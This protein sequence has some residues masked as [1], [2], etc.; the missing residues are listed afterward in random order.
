M[1][2]T[3]ELFLAHEDAGYAGQAAR[4][5]FR[6]LDR[7]DRELSRFIPSS[8]VARIN[9][10]AAGES[11]TI[12]LAAWEC[13]ALAAR[14]HARTDGAFDV[15]IGLLLDW[16]RARGDAGDCAND[17]QWLAA[18]ART[19]MGLLAV[20]AGE[21]AVT[22]RE[23][24]VRVD[25]G[26]IGKGYAVD[27]MAALLREWSIQAALIHGGQSSVLAIGS[28]PDRDDWRVSLRNP[29]DH[30]GEPFGSLRLRDRS[31]GGSGIQLHG[32]HIIDP[33]TGRPAEGKLG[34]WVLAPAA[35]QA[36]ALSTAF[37]VLAESEIEEYCRT[38]EEISA[39]LW[40]AEAEQKTLRRW[41]KW[42][43]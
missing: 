1:A 41:G 13:L 23:A 17:P 22:A 6:E 35:A 33:R 24:G 9:S 16:W 10:L 27:Q 25:L 18:R 32:R 34:T 11:V 26:A 20:S 40:L 2:T 4:A 5:A 15:T 14:I 29:E 39:M 21:P 28:P 7:L 38:H 43:G 8:D 12:G 37:M 36:D 3:F 42:E 31:L 19:G 30:G